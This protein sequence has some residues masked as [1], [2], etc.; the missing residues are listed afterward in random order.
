MSDVDSSPGLGSYP[1]ISSSPSSCASIWTISPGSE[2]RVG[3]RYFAASSSP[4][5]PSRRR[6]DPWW[7]VYA[8]S[9]RR[10]GIAPR[11]S[12][13]PIHV[14]FLRCCGPCQAASQTLGSSSPRGLCIAS[15][16]VT[17]VGPQRRSTMSAVEGTSAVSIAVRPRPC[18]RARS[19]GRLQRSESRKLPHD[20]NDPELP[21]GRPLE[22]NLRR[23][24]TQRPSLLQSSP[25][26]SSPIVK[27][28]W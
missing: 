25:A 3:A 28:S 21:F 15:I 4:F 14:R 22:V 11:Q 24:R 23:C 20:A 7:S 12:P 1:Y 18:P 26:S 17:V 8:E 13:N 19:V 5:G 16:S 6:A 10:C 9:R 2:P 27:S